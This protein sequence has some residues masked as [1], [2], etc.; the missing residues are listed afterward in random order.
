[1]IT[2]TLSI[3]LHYFRHLSL[4]NNHIPSDSPSVVPTSIL[5]IR[6]SPVPSILPI[7]VPKDL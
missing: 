7:K 5:S 6:P 4:N 1:M 2:Y 3:Q